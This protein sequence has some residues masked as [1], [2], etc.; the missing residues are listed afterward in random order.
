MF[1][2]LEDEDLM[3]AF[4]TSGAYEDAAAGPPSPKAGPASPRP[5]TRGS[6]VSAGPPS[7][8]PA[9]SSSRKRRSATADEDTP[10]KL[11][12]SAAATPSS[13]GAG[14]AGGRVPHGKRA[15]SSTSN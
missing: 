6:C 10:R 14:K 5:V 12:G 8:P 9:T 2:Q 1:A 15:K 13:A 4:D 7:P 3:Q 11:R